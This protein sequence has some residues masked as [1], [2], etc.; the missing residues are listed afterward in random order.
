MLHIKFGFDFPSG[1][2]GEYVGIVSWH[3]TCTVYCPGVG[4]DETLGS[5]CFQKM[6]EYHGNIHVYCPGLG[7]DEPLSSIFFPESLIF[8]ST[9]HPGLPVTAN[10]EV[11]GTRR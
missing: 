2:R 11:R 7:S 1:F 3:Y 10:S 9:A 5:N 6:F 8:S 4:T